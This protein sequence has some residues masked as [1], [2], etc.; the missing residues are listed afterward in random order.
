MVGSYIQGNYNHSQLTTYHAVSIRNENGG[1]HRIF[2]PS[3]QPKD[4]RAS[5]WKD[6]GERWGNTGTT[7]W[8]VHRRFQLFLGH[9]TALKSKG[10][11]LRRRPT[12]NCCLA[13][14]SRITEGRL[15]IRYPVAS[16]FLVGHGLV[17]HHYHIISIIIITPEFRYRRITRGGLHLLLERDVY[18]AAGVVD[19]GALPCVFDAYEAPSVDAGDCHHDSINNIEPPSSDE[20]CLW[21]GETRQSAEMFL[22]DADTG[23]GSHSTSGATSF[24]HT[25]SGLD[26][27]PGSD[28][29]GWGTTP[30]PSALLGDDAIPCEIG[31]E[32]PGHLCC[33]PESNTCGRSKSVF[34]WQRTIMGV[35]IGHICLYRTVSICKGHR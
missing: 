2:I 23:E 22:A 1:D 14:L 34:V 5:C 24:S 13:L 35:R 15:Q 9:S 3:S 18:C 26:T 10:L 19:T 16:A 12:T 32:C 7:G 8:T 30:A 31:I 20:P 29:P 6:K 25:P 21:A 11:P 28:A 33:H 17:P 4:G 27:S